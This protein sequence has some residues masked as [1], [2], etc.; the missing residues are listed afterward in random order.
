VSPDQKY[1]IV[2]TLIKRGEIVAMTGDGINDAPA[3][4]RANIGSVWGGE[5]PR[6][7]SLLPGMVLLEDD[8][9]ALITTIREGR[10]LFDNIQQASRYVIG[11]KVM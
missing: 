6:S 1:A 4:R 2:D 10:H 9:A 8:F 5:Q 3:L 7:R 11:F